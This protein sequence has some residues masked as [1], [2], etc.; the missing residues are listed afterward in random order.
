M[1]RAIERIVFCFLACL[2]FLLFLPHRGQAHEK[3][4]GVGCLLSCHID[5]EIMS[6]HSTLDCTDCHEGETTYGNVYTTICIECHPTAG[7]KS[8]CGLVNYH[9]PDKDADCLACHGECNPDITTT[10]TTGPPIT[11][12]TTIAESC[13]PMQEALDSLNS[14][15]EVTVTKVEVEEPEG[16]SYYYYAFKPNKGQP[17]IGFIIYRIV[18]TLLNPTTSLNNICQIVIHIHL[19]CT[20]GCYI[21]R[22]D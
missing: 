8:Q 12:T 21:G 17:K 9:V 13:T 10:T 5:Y 15:G 7:E 3:V 6:S 20:S 2:A 14:D 19:S 18:K 22:N 11:T 16:E 4:T 1:M